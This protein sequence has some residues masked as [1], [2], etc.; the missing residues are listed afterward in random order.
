MKK[1]LQDFNIEVVPLPELKYSVAHKAEL[2][3]L[4]DTRGEAADLPSLGKDLATV[5]LP[6]E[7][8]YQLE[9]CISREIINEYNI[10]KDFL[11]ALEKLASA[12][13]S[14][15][16]NI[17][18][19][20]AENYTRLYHPMTIF[21]NQEALAFSSPTVETTNRIL[22]NYSKEN[23]KGRFLRVQFTDEKYEDDP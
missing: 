21:D 4:V 18:E 9:V 17:L 23:G 16:Q 12:D 10:D 1:A 20:V 3:S 7:V 14:K 13:P 22:R 15:A 6:F 19:Y 5:Q 2:W 11:N 8:R